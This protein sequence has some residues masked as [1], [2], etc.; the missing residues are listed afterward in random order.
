MST[1]STRA[2]EPSRLIAGYVALHSRRA[3]QL[4]L[5]TLGQ[6]LV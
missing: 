2:R 3:D 4:A 6:T 1:K 5:H